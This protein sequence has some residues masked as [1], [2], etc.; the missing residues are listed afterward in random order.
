MDKITR[1][2][3]RI[4][5]VLETT[6]SVSHS[7]HRFDVAVNDS[8]FSVS[9]PTLKASTMNRKA[10][11]NSSSPCSRCGWL[12]DVVLRCSNFIE[13]VTVLCSA[14]LYFVVECCGVVCCV[15][16]CC[17]VLCCAGC[18]VL[19]GMC[20]TRACVAVVPRGP[21]ERLRL[22]ARGDLQRSGWRGG[23]FCGVRLLS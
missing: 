11:S 2:T 15:V 20:R 4:H 21:T 1:T 8:V 9:A 22:I 17:G 10:K 6:R 16:L 13:L 7:L 3:T 18:V 23:L 5:D 19:C 12:I 14:V